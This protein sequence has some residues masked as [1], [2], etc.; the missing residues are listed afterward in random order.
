MLLVDLPFT[1]EL[2]ST[3]RYVDRDY[4]VHV[5]HQSGKNICQSAFFFPFAVVL[6]VTGKK[7]I[8][9]LFPLSDDSYCR[10]HVSF[11]TNISALNK[12][13]PYLMSLRL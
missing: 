8:N 3:S 12:T 2:I 6:P 9:C 4:N 5:Q 10:G 13:I 1:D 11:T 7:Y